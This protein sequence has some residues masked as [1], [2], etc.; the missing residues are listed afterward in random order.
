MALTFPQSPS[1]NDVYTYQ[2]SSYV[3]DGDKWTSRAQTSGLPLLPDSNGNVSVT[4]SLTVAST[5]SASGFRVDLL[6]TL[7]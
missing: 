3:W 6:T 5:V 4:G 1:V 7:P 2:G